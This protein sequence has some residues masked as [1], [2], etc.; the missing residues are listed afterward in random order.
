MYNLILKNPEGISRLAAIANLSVEELT[1]II[2]KNLIDYGIVADDHRFCGKAF[3]KLFDDFVDIDIHYFIMRVFG[4]CNSEI[5]RLFNELYFIYYLEDCPE[6]GYET[7]A[8]DQENGKYK[9]EDTKCL[10]SDCDYA[11]SN[12]PDWDIM[13]GGHDYY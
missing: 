4:I 8:L 11:I 12:E 5:L 2:C 3:L 13:P 6:C 9:W 10:N 1:D 7:E